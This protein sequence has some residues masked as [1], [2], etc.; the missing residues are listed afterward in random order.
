MA[1]VNKIVLP[2]SPHNRLAEATDAQRTA[3]TVVNHKSPRRVNWKRRP[4][5]DAALGS[6]VVMLALLVIA[7][8]R[9]A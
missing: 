5:I 8:L 3:T 2:K 7:S 6:G 1:I 9:V 4:G